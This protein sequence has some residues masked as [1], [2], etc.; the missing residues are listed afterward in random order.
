MSTSCWGRKII[1]H[2]PDKQSMQ[3][4]NQ[5]II[6]DLISSSINIDVSKC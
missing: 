1:E 6:E 2:M 5:T 3:E 4:N